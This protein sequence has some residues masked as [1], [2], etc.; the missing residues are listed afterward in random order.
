VPFDGWTRRAMRAG[1]AELGIDD[2]TADNLLPGGATEAMALFHDWADRE[3]LRCYEAAPREG[4]RTRDK[5]ALALK[6]RL[7]ACL[8]FREA[9]RQ[10]VAFLAQPQ[11]A[12][13]AT[14]LAWRSCDIVWRA[15][16]DR[17]AD[18]NYY[19]KR[20]LLAA[21]YGSAV[22]YWL[23]DKSTDATATEAFIDRRIG[24]VM[25]V[26]SM[27]ADVRKAAERRMPNPLR[28]FRGIRNPRRYRGF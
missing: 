8:P 17:S 16:G 25:K 24:D 18:F 19:T 12:A 11:H 23:A 5:A 13:L 28:F 14:K 2:A 3:M 10:G 6:L 21:V 22:M 20:G 4:L 26:P 15:L 9:V 1:A 7:R 27:M